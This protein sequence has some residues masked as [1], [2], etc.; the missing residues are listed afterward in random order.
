MQV[1]WSDEWLDFQYRAGFSLVLSVP[2]MEQVLRVSAPTSEQLDVQGLPFRAA[3]A[4]AFQQNALLLAGSCELIRFAD[5]FS[6]GRFTGADFDMCLVPN[7]LWFVANLNVTDVGLLARNQPIFASRKFSCLATVDP[8]NSFAPLWKPSFIDEYKAEDS[9]GLSGMSMVGNQ[10]T[11]VTC[12]GNNSRP[13]GWLS[14][15]AGVLVDVLT[16][17]TVCAGLSRPTLPRWYRGGLYMVEA[18]TGSFGKV[19]LTTGQFESIAFCPGFVES[20]CF[21][22]DY[23]ILSISTPQAHSDILDGCTLLAQIKKHDM[24]LRCGI[25]AI[26]LKTGE[27]LQGLAFD[28]QVGQVSGMALIP[29]KRLPHI[30]SLASKDVSEFITGG[31]FQPSLIMSGQA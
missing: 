14:E 9:C 24:P 30:I 11:H 27:L 16:D 8:F 5:A 18:G 22:S 17:E 13:S 6:P 29:Q 21:V 2:S 7:Q 23:A 31:P 12:F 15:Q 4:M 19:N 26:N 1:H 3:G 10:P 20:L 28:E 25:V